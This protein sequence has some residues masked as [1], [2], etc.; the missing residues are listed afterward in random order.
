MTLSELD[1]GMN[2]SDLCPS[3][4]P[5]PQSIKYPDYDLYVLS[6]KVF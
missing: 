3:P 2:L 4:T 1:H 6:P 5:N